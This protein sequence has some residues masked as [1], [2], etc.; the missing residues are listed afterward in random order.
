MHEVI[1]L[2]YLG[3]IWLAFASVCD[4]RSREIPN[5]INFSLIIFAIGFRF[6]YSL[7]NWD[8]NFFYQGLIG[9]GI[10][11]VLGNLFY[12]GR[13]FAGGDGKLMIAMG[14]ILPLSLD[15][16]SNVKIFGIFLFLFLIIGGIYGL[17]WSFALIAG[18][19][20]KFKKE[21]AQQFGKNKFYALFIFGLSLII[22]LFG[23]YNWIFF[24]AGGMGFLFFLLLISANSIEKVCMVKEISVKKLTEGDWLYE[25]VKIGKNILKSSWAGLNKKEI[26]LLKK[27][28]KNVKVKYG[29]PFVPVFLIAFLVLIYLLLNGFNLWNSFWQP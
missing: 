2:I 21:F 22:F 26:L 6:F 15:F 7:F 13:L 5:W 11:F 19:F 28:K 29:I 8:F 23:F 17:V 4:L 18:N 14:V 1:F 20:N 16:Y 25:D 24:Y 3:V 12:Y 9:L 10:F 27:Y